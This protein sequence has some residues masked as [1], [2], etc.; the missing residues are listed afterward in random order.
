VGT[1]IAPGVT[2]ELPFTV[3]VPAG[4]PA[5]RRVLT[6]DLVLRGRPRGQRAESIVDVELEA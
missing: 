1:T 5:G 2:A 3:R 4:E 6:A